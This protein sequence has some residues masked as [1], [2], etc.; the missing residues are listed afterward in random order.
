MIAIMDIG[1]LSLSL[2]RKA[3]RLCIDDTDRDLLLDASK[4]PDSV[5]IS[6]WY[7]K[8]PSVG[9]ASRQPR[10]ENSIVVPIAAKLAST[11]ATVESIPVSSVVSSAT[12]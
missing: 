5:I 4:W 10:P 6:V 2:R 1:P 7:Y 8:P 9:T 11:A 12:C 3:F